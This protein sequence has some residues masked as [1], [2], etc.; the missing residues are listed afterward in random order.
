MEDVGRHNAVDKIAGW[1]FRNRVAAH[2]KIF[3]TTGRLTSEMV[4]KT[5]RMGIPILV[6]RSGFTA[7]GV[8]LARKSGLTLIGRA[9]GKRFVALSGE[10]RI[11]FDQDLA[12]VEDE[13]GK[14]RRKAAVHDD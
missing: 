4:I 10:D 12:Y 7:W 13:G 14:H 2:D 8:E 3:Y 5:V 9:R 1:M 6:S 11:V